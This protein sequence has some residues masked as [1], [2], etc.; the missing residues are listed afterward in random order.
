MFDRRSPVP[1]YY[2]I[3]KYIEDLIENKN[4]KQGDRIPSEHELTEQ[5]QVSRMTVRQ[6]VMD[7][8]NAGILMRRKGKGTFVSGQRK[9]EK[10]L[11]GLNGFTEDMIN[12]G[13]KPDSRLLDFQKMRPP[14]PV[15]KRLSLEDEEEVYAIKRTRLAD[16]LPMAIETTFI[17][18]ALVPNLSSGAFN[19]SLYDY[20]EK[21]Y[22]L[23]LDHADQS[24]EAA[25]VT[26]EEAA[27]L[28]VP[29]GS[30]VL[31][32][33]RCSYLAGEKALEY[34]RS[35]YRADR[36]KFMIRLPRK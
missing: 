22:G 8:V 18:A 36:Y 32:I 27:I 2:Q 34:T 14:A 15:R 16:D 13:M 7:L 29:K 4:L 5:F 6:A 35:L 12:R 11:N 17:P 21:K 33:E 23:I 28:E 26:A 30:P 9:I 19:Q 3:E 31:L 20:I 10:S 25:L 1:M 24:L